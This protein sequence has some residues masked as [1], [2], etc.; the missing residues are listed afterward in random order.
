MMKINFRGVVS[1]SSILTP[2]PN[3]INSQIFY[4]QTTCSAKDKYE[5]SSSYPYLSLL[6]VKIEVHRHQISC[7]ERDPN[8]RPKLLD[9]MLTCCIKEAQKTS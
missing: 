6:W 3:L 2:F 1:L 5:K 4:F 8:I 9:T 7:I